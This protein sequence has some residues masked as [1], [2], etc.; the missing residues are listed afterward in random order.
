MSFESTTK[1]LPGRT[2][3]T[4]AAVLAALS[5]AIGAIV[6]VLI[7]RAMI[8]YSITPFAPDDQITVTVHDRSVAL[9]MTPET[10]GA[11]CTA[12]NDATQQPSAHSGSAD[13]MTITDGGHTWT[14][15]GVVEG[16][17]GST[18][19]VTCTGYGTAPLPQL[20]GYA[21]NPRIARY[22]TL[23]VVGGSIAGLSALASV[24]LIIVTAVR[25][26]NARKAA[27]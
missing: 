1:R 23:G 21:P 16:P 13:T 3:F 24:A 25:R 20:L 14:R 12:I 5:I 26:S 18:H 22:V 6:A 15:L 2:G 4:V 9:W 7:V 10:A 8:G 27:A 19:S 17:P 11:N